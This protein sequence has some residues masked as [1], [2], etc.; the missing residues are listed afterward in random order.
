MVFRSG[1][2][3]PGVAFVT[4]GA[5]GLGNAIA[6]SF[7]KD[8]AR[9]VVIVDILSD[10]LLEA[11]RK[12]VE[13]YGARCIAIKADVTKEDDVARAIEETIT[14]FGRIDY[15]ANFAG[16][17]GPINLR[18]WTTSIET[19]RKVLEVNTIGVWICTSQLIKAMMKQEAVEL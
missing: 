17:V 7:A 10:D 4:G 14:T 8:G 2:L 13:T 12:N 18:M 3:T 6:V 15:A 11:G 16:I 9:G 19:V 5:R 1:P